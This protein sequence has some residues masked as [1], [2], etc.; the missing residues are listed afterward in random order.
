MK[1]ITDPLLQ[2]IYEKE[3]QHVLFQ[4]A[5]ALDSKNWEALK[6]VFHPEVKVNYAD[7]FLLNGRENV[8]HM[9][10]SM[11]ET[12]G[13]TQHLLGNYQI[14]TKG[15]SATSECYVR[16]A[17][18]G[19]GLFSVFN[20]TVMAIYKDQLTLTDQ[21]WRIV[22]RQMQ[23]SRNM[24]YIVAMG[25]GLWRYYLKYKIKGGNIL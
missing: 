11:L 7:V 12:C 19:R 5:K 20:W 10:K 8:I 4:Y 14:H 21:G 22:E 6:D 9:I 24:G 13:R 1:N 23:G 2:L 25:T 15:K 16:A 17:H 3:I 18:A